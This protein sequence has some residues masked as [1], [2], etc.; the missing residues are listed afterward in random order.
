MKV[1]NKYWRYRRGLADEA[2]ASAV[3][4]VGGALFE[5]AVAHARCNLANFIGHSRLQPVQSSYRNRLV[6]QVFLDMSEL[7]SRPQVLPSAPQAGSPAQPMTRMRVFVE[8]FD[9]SATPLG[10]MADWPVSLRAVVSLMLD[11]PEAMVVWWGEDLRQIYNDAHTPR[12]ESDGRAT[13]LGQPAAGHWRDGWAAVEPQVDLVLAGQPSKSYKDYLIHISRNGR[14]DDTYWTYAFTPMRHDAG[15]IRG[16]LV[17]S[18]E[19]TAQVLSARRQETRDWLRQQLA[20]VETGEALEQAVAS[21]AQVNPGDCTMSPSFR[22]R[23]EHLP[24]RCPL[25]ACASLQET[26][27]SIPMSR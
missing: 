3:Y 24:R 25:H 7:S 11:S 9:W 2:F 21:A 14:V 20:N 18:T 10:A 4:S 13:A 19:T 15:V 5:I 17:T 16:V 27:A 12:V 8:R 1:S 6:S 23:T 22:Q 26:S